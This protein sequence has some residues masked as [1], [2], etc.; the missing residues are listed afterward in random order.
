MYR[1]SNNCCAFILFSELVMLSDLWNMVSALRRY[2]AV[3]EKL[4]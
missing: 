2:V 1:N 3:R 4:R